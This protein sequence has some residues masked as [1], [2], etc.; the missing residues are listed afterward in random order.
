M[1]TKLTTVVYQGYVDTFIFKPTKIQ[2][3]TQALI[4]IN[5]FQ[6][7]YINKN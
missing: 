7:I 4:F 6:V 3:D 2:G 1:T 5:V